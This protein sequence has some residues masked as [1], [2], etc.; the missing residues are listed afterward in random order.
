MSSSASNFNEQ[1]SKYKTYMS[2][3]NYSAHIVKLKWLIGLLRSTLKYSFLIAI[4]IKLRRHCK[5]NVELATPYNA[6]ETAIFCRTKDPITTM[7]KSNVICTTE[8]LGC[9]GLY[10]GKADHCFIRRLDKHGRKTDQQSITNGKNCADF[11][12]YVQMFK[13]PRLFESYKK[14]LYNTIATKAKEI[15]TN[16]NL[17]QL[18]F[19]SIL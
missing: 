13:S 17:S 12:N 11:N 6:K 10:F 7:Q 15:D 18:C 9:H 5:Y 2:W 19:R 14:F 1:L 4:V 8:C 16:Q 3:N